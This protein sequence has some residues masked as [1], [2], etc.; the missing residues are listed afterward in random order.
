MLAGRSI[1]IEIIDELKQIWTVSKEK[2]RVTSVLLTP[3]IVIT[4]GVELK[5]LRWY[6]WTMS[7]LFVTW[8]VFGMD[9][10]SLGTRT[11]STLSYTFSHYYLISMIVLINSQ[12]SWMAGY[13]ASSFGC[14]SVALEGSGDVHQLVQ[15]HR[16]LTVSC[17][18]LSKVY[19]VEILILFGTSLVSCTVEAY[20]TYNIL[21][22]QTLI[23]IVIS[24]YWTGILYSICFRIIASCVRAKSKA[25]E[26]D[27]AIYK[28]IVFNK[29]GDFS[30]YGPNY[31]LYFHFQGS[32]GVTFDALGFFQIDWQLART[33]IAA[34]I[35]YV[36]ILVQFS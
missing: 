24:V 33:M 16:R 19:S 8:L 7:T 17:R 28:S 9:C 13:I 18:M 5:P 31:R 12:I 4:K 2:K 22:T 23:H 1:I 29:Q 21:L 30:F 3:V 26:F 34:G 35:A 32:S 27:A 10:Y 20:L 36:V 14:L 25:M 15:W 11:F 6:I